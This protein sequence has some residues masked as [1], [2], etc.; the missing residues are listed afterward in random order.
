M[1]LV[2]AWGMWRARYWAVL[3]MQ[4]I[5]AFLLI[6][7]SLNLMYAVVNDELLPAAGSLAVVAGRRRAVLVHGQG[8]GA[9]PDAGAPLTGVPAALRDGPHA[10]MAG[11][12]R[13]VG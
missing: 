12:V 9:D 4:A 3:G 11:A 10:T 6:G 1:L 8:D 7:F 5:L 13:W 2:A